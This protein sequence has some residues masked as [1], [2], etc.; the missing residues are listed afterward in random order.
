M[1]LSYSALYLA[2]VETILTVSTYLVRS[3]VVMVVNSFLMRVHSVS[4]PPS[5]YAPLTAL[6]VLGLPLAT[7]CYDTT[8]E[9]NHDM[10]ES[11]GGGG[12]GGG[13]WGGGGN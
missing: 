13:G 4:F 1:S 10:Y 2:S 8:R 5:A 12:K 9:G 7:T 3:A 6:V 11:M